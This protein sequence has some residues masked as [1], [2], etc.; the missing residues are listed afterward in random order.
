MSN[1]NS[2]DSH[3]K[4][5]I[6]PNSEAQKHFLGVASHESIAAGIQPNSAY[7]L[8]YRGGKLLPN[9]QFTIFYVGGSQ[10]WQNSDRTNIDNALSAAMSDTNLNNVMTQYFNDQSLTSV[11][12]PSTILSAAAPSQVAQSDIE[13]MLASMYTGGQLQAYDLTSTVFCFILPSG[14]VLSDG[15]V[16]SQQGLG[17]FHGAVQSGSATLYYAVVAYA[18]NQA[19]GQ[20]NGIVAFNAPWKNITAA[21]YHELNESRTD[22]DVNGVPG[23]LSNPISDFGGQSVE[24]GDAPVF[25][26]G[27]NLGLVFKEVPLTNGNGT[28]PIQ[29]MYSD[30]VHG[31][32]GP[33]TTPDPPATQTAPA[34]GIGTSGIASGWNSGLLFLAIALGVIIVGLITFM[35]LKH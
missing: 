33:Q 19:N 35:L 14:V 24:V 8:Y 17:G 30:A 18:E 5:V 7:D 2:A 22:P 32:E 12:K 3:L 9:L 27:S 26:A 10:V 34:N 21:L 11:F 15:N 13:S 20:M 28:V 16:N 31:P 6:R 1:R 25:E 29:L 23:W 4:V